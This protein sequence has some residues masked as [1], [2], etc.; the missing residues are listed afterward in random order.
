[1]EITLLYYTANKENPEF[2]KKI[3]ANLPTHLPI[4]SVSQKPINLGKNICVGEHGNSYI[5]E[6]RQILIGLREIKTEYFI[7]CEADFLYPPDYFTFEPNGAN[8]YRSDNVWIVYDKFC[9]KPYSE[10]AQIA[11]TKY[12][13]KFIEH[14][15]EGL[16]EW[17]DGRPNDNKLYMKHQKELWRLPFTFFHTSPCLSFKTG[18]GI[19]KGTQITDE[20]ATELPIWGDIIN[21]KKQYDY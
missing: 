17:Y 16:P 20:G 19:R 14:Y 15:L 8:V 11:K 12:M 21:L 7:S 13:I 10:G 9:K 5:N 2:E 18:N 4:V 1:M 3:Q 6:Y